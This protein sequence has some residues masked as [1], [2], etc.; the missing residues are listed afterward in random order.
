MR[1]WRRGLF[2]RPAAQSIAWK[3]DMGCYHACE[4]LRVLKEAI[5]DSKVVSSDEHES[6]AGAVAISLLREILAEGN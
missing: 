2:A 4:S 5:Y 3:L 1:G 6:I